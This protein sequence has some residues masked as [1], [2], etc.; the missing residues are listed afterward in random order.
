MEAEYIACSSVISEAIW[1][2]G[3]HKSLNIKEIPDEPIKVMCD[4][5]ASIC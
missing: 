3:F 4:I 1:I 2:K 5:Q